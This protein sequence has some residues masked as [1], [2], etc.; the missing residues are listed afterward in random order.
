MNLMTLQ[1]YSAHVR[2][3]M[4]R[5]YLYLIFFTALFDIFMNYCCIVGLRQAIRSK[6]CE[7]TAHAMLGQQEEPKKFFIPY[8]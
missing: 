6:Q 4:I 8:R 1:A 3:F 7:S 2:F 5:I